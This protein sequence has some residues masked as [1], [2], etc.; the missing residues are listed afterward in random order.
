MLVQ[1]GKGAIYTDATVTLPVLSLDGN[2]YYVVVCDYDNNF[3]KSQE[4]S[5]LKNET[6]VETVQKIF[7]KMKEKGHKLL[8]NVK[9]QPG[10]EATESVFENKRMQVAIR[11]TT[12]PQSECNGKSDTNVQKL[13]Y[14]RFLLYE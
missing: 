9:R 7:H 14:P 6:I 3:I 12:Q 10:G 13:P 8:L 2:Q 4:V 1:K 11:G 5:D